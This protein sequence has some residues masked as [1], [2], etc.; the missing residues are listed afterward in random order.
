MRL[1]TRIFLFKINGQL[2]EFNQ[3]IVLLA[4]RSVQHILDS[5]VADAQ[6]SRKVLASISTS[7]QHDGRTENTIEKQS[8]DL[9]FALYPDQPLK[10]TAEIACAY[11]LMLSRFL[12]STLNPNVNDSNVVISAIRNSLSNLSSRILSTEWNDRKNIDEDALKKLLTLQIRYSPSPED[13]MLVYASQGIPALLEKQSDVQPE[14]F[15]VLTRETLAVHF[16]VIACELGPNLQSKIQSKSNE[17]EAEDEYR[18][19]AIDKHCAIFRDLMAVLKT[20][21][22]RSILNFSL[23]YGRQF[24]E[25]FSRVALPIIERSLVAQKDRTGAILRSLQNG[26]RTLQNVCAHAKTLKDPGLTAAVPLVRKALESF[27]FTI[28]AMLGKHNSLGALWIG[29]LKHRDLR[30]QIVSSQIAAAS[31]KRALG[32]K[33]KKRR[34]RTAVSE[35]STGAELMIIDEAPSRI[36]SNSTVNS[37]DSE[38]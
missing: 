1:A 2:Q 17:A 4:I 24:V 23:K 20:I 21:D 9:L 35:T 5:A 30:G 7:G 10:I 37:S 25:I 38:N 26:T 32:E 13:V 14:K 12:E 18:L 11:L 16:Q 19:N 34:K 15:P 22:T 33:P 27:I 28:K 36:L 6:W 3:E 29:N 31:L 8:F